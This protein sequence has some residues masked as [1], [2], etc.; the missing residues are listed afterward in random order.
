MSILRFY[1]NL[2]IAEKM[3]ITVM[4]ASTFLLVILAG[5]FI[6]DK[7]ITF[8]R[9]AVESTAT[10]ASV[11]G[12]NSAAALVFDVPAT[13]KDI[14][15]GLS[16]EP[17]VLTAGILKADG[18]LFATYQ[19][20]S[21]TETEPLDMP[22]I[23]TFLAQFSGAANK[24]NGHHFS[25]QHLDFVT[26]IRLKEKTIGY[27][28]LRRDLTSLTKRIY[29]SLAGV[30]LITNALFVVVHLLCKPLHRV[31]VTPLII[32][33]K[34]MA[35]VTKNSNY[36][37]RV[38]SYNQDEVGV[39]IRGFND[40]LNQIQ[41]REKEL[42]T[43]RNHL[44]DLVAKRTQAL[45]DSNE[46][47]K[48]EIEERKQAQ[49][50]LARAQKMEAIGTLA[51][52]VAHDLNNIL[53]GIVSY[54][55]LLLL[56]LPEDSPLRDSLE[57]IHKTGQ[58]AAA[59]VQDLLTLARRGVKTTEIVDMSKL[60][61]SYLNSPEHQK[62]MSFHPDVK[63]VT[64]IE[65]NLYNISGSPVHIEKCIMNLVANAAEAIM[66]KGT[67]AIGLRNRYVAESIQ[68]YD[69]VKEGDYVVLSVSDTGV[70]ID[71]E[72]IDRI[73]EP[74]YTKKKMGRSGTGLGMAVV[75]G[76]VKDH[77]GYIDID[78]QPGEGTTIKLYFLASRDVVTPDN[79]NL[80]VNELQGSGQSILVVD[81][82]KEQREIATK[83][84][85]Y[86]GYR[87][88]AVSS[89]EAAI[90]FLETQSVDLLLLDMI[91][92][93]GM[94]G[95][96]TY[97]EIKQRRPDQRVI[98]ASGFSESARVKAAQELGAG[99]YVRKPYTLERIGLAVKKELARR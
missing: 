1:K 28:F 40:M 30:F 4:V 73:F 8:R 26:P 33:S 94:D 95:L 32:L 19:S 37:L 88:T 69:S 12:T 86:L 9:N 91:M 61:K 59:I 93:P 27:A 89:G 57:T 66:D 15:D 64:E 75:W 36:T 25:K 98:I 6:T 80:P 13:A 3:T 29:W 38:T 31:I 58:K 54:P 20:S 11:I 16:A 17:D 51:A 7:I 46:K 44:E 63:V 74:F 92:D 70:G 72:D 42:E 77:N 81:D 78:S 67:L 47:L 83:I 35:S 14:L 76:T 23:E 53:S 56:T 71:P 65:S 43:H 34:A 96:E 62:I 21:A 49:D 50:K 55:Q 84:L 10:L 52:G 48:Q 99:E 68:G 87:V 24:W 22:F 2:S 18:H 45:I 82:V 41:K 5:L 90:N 97:Q 85:A 79:K 39:L 60:L